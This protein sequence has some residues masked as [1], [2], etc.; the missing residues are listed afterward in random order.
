MAVHVPQG[1][2]LSGVYCGLKRDPRKRDL[3]LVVC[4]QPAAAAGVYTRNLVH[5]APVA[6]DRARTP[7][8]RIRAVVINSGNANAC[9]GEK[10]M[11]DAREM[12][13]LAAAACGAAEDQALVLSTGII[14]AYLPMEKIAKGIREAAERLATDDAS[15]ETA[16]RGMLT[17]DTVPKLAG[18]TVAIR[19][20]KIQ[21]TGMAK[22]AAM[23]APNMATMLGLIMTDAKLTPEAAQAGL[24]AATEDSFNCL[25][26]D[27]HMSTNDTVLLVASGATGGEPL[28]AT[29]RR[30]TRLSTRSALIWPRRS[31]TTARAPAT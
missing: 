13:R 1:F 20:Q 5:A 7:S 19:G 3:V 17:T 10:G 30:S 26:V 18:R 21:I 2:R 8:S 27:G 16:A 14:G 25:T 23:I 6:L 29:W 11:Q 4:D 15:L 28:S 22:G 31:P 9:T 12:A 24:S